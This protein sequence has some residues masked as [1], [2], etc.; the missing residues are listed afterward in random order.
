MTGGVGNVATVVVKKGKMS[1]KK[2][3]HKALIIRQKFPITR[4]KGPTMGKIAFRDNAAVLLDPQG[5]VIKDTIKGP[6]AKEILQIK[7]SFSGL[8][9]TY[10]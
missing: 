10:K 2:K 4:F 6:V 1:L 3:V 8:N 7:K 9:A 5:K